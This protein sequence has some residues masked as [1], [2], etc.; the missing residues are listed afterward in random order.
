MNRIDR[1]G[2]E[3]SMRNMPRFV[4]YYLLGFAIYALV[5]GVYLWFASTYS[6][7]EPYRGTAADPATFLSEK[8]LDQSAVYSAV[9]NWL[10]FIGYPWEWGIYVFLLFS[11]AAWRWKERLENTSWS[12]AVRFPV[13]VFLLSFVS[14]LSFL[15]IRFAGY[16]LSKGYGIS[17]QTFWS[18]VRDKAVGFGIDY[19]ILILT[20]SVAF[21]LI[22]RGGRWW[23]KLWLLSIPFTVFLMYLQPVII[24]PLYNNFSQLSDP[25]LE[26]QILTLA[27]RAGIPAN[28]VYEVNMSAKTNALNAYVNGL[29]TSL[30]IVLW[31]TTLEQ[32][33]EKEILF[34][35]AHEMGHYVMHHLEWSALGAVVFSFFLIWIGSRLYHCAI[36]RWG[37]KWGISKVND[38]AALPLILLILSMLSFS[39]TPLA[40]FVSRQAEHAADRY[41]LEL[42]EH[43]DGAISMYQK[44]ASSSLSEVNPPF[45]VKVYRSS[46]PSIMERI[47][48]VET[49]ESPR[50]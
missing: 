23:V 48:Y 24:D 36:R 44:L 34:I 2:Q 50:K 37:N 32:L 47:I 8:Q 45:L 6:V 33:N 21:W 17:T 43:T 27:D 20:S 38:F 49:Y 28:R 22:G 29:G 11:G 4:R 46:H 18:W 42:T 1:L 15:P 12:A 16:T 35:M 5:I 31:D 30:R 10:F 9:R 26:H 19:L 14:F 39:L 7:P 13:Y 41:A 3:E 25:H 40:N